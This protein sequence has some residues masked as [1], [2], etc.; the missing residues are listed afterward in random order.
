MIPRVLTL[1]TGDSEARDAGRR[2]L[3]G[4]KW[5]AYLLG[6]GHYIL[7]GYM[8]HLMTVFLGCWS[9]YPHFLSNSPPPLTFSWMTLT[10]P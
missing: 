1:T 4:G 2:Q 3:G 7:H 10:Q 6:E 9:S 5:D 8:S